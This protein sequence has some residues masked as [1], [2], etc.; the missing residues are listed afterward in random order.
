MATYTKSVSLV[1]PLTTADQT[2]LQ[3]NPMRSYALLVNNSTEE[4]YLGM[5]IPAV[6]GRGI[7]LLTPGSNYEI[8]LIN[9]F[10][11]EIHALVAAAT[12]DLLITEW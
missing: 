11:G 6:S 2:V 8:T 5:G 1:A 9:P 7:P 10:H 12:G 3:E 4:I